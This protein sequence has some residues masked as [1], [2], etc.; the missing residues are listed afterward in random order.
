MK[1]DRLVSILKHEAQAHGQLDYKHQVVAILEDY[2]VIKTRLEEL[3]EAIRLEREREKVVIETAF[4]ANTPTNVFIEIRDR[5]HAAQAAVDA[6]VE[7]K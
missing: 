5:Y 4:D 7:E 6:L 3:K 2:K 1:I